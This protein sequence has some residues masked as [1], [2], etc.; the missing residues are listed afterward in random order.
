MNR[1][2]V[3]LAGIAMLSLGALAAYPAAAEPRAGVQVAQASPLVQEAYIRGI[4]TQL[5]SHGYD[6]GPVDGVMGSQTRAAIRA[7]QRDAGLAVDGEAGPGLLDHLKFVQ[8]P[9][10]RDA[11]AARFA[12]TD[13]QRALAERGYYTG[14]LDGV[15]G[16]MTR[17][18]LERFRQ[19]ARLP[20]VA[21][22]DSRTPIEVRDAP[23][24]IKAGPQ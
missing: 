21:G 12:V 18:A 22:I 23:A 6:A 5:R 14:P 11:A 15:T 16:P 1:T 13:T 9:V 10:T 8:P 24:N 17:S 7:Y 2:S 19:D 20:E 4:Q 3:T